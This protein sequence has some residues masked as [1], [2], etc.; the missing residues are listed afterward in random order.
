MNAPAKRETARQTSKKAQ[1]MSQYAQN[2]DEIVC[3]DS[4]NDCLTINSRFGGGCSDVPLLEAIH[5]CVLQGATVQ[6]GNILVSSACTACKASPP[7]QACQH[8]K[9]TALLLLRWQEFGGSGECGCD[10][11]PVAQCQ[12][13]S[14]QW[15][16]YKQTQVVCYY[17][18]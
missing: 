15:A 4:L 5:Q 18:K 1:H 8:S 17:L 3:R 13:T 7:P 6:K 10:G 11:E 14:D 2:F 9:C 12:K 16:Q